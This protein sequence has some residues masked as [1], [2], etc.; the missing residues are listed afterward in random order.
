MKLSDSKDET[1]RAREKSP[2]KRTE[3][4]SAARI[5]KGVVISDDDEDEVPRPPPPV[6]P[7]AAYKAKAKAATP[8]SDAEKELRAMMNIDDGKKSSLVHP[9]SLSLWT[10]KS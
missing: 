5:K 6:R 2:P 4:K 1:A 9:L 10:K 7:K 3:S 8:D